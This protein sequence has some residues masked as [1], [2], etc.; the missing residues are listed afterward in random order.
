VPCHFVDT[1]ALA[2]LYH[3]EPG[4]GRLEELAREPGSKLIISQLSLVEIQSV[5][6]GKVR[7]RVIPESALGLLR[8]R[9]YAD[10]A[11]GRLHVA[12]VGSRHWTIAA[13][14]VRD[15]AVSHGLRTLDAVQLAVAI[16]LHRRGAAATLVASDHNLCNVAA[17]Q[18][19]SVLNPSAP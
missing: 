3:A 10:L 8:G 17:L 16:D 4:S 14:L 18:G 12:L 6:A 15:F 11:E 5:F 19:L 9:F 7:T 2:K 13:Q 1:S